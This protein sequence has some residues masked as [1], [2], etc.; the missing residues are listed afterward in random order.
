MLLRRSI[1]S[2][3]G[4]L[5]CLGS[6]VQA[7][8]VVV[9]GIDG[10]DPGLLTQFVD[11]G[12]MPH[13]ARLMEEGDFRPLETSVVPQSP[14][15]WS[16]FSTGL[17]PG[18]HGIYG[19]VH[20]DP[21]TML[22]YLSTSRAISAE[23]SIGLGSFALPLG[24]GKV[25]LLRRGRTFWELLGEHGVPTTL[26]R[27]PANFPPPEVELS[28]QIAGMGTPDLLG[29]PGTYSLYSERPAVDADQFDGGRVYRVEV[30][31]GCVE[32]KLYGPENPYRRTV[33]GGGEYEPSVATADFE[34]GIDRAAGAAR[35]A[36]GEGEFVLQV[37][38]W[39]EWVR[40][41]FELL[42]WLAGT[43][44]L[45]R[46][47]LKRLE[48]HF[49]LYVSPL[50][51]NPEDA[52]MR[53]ST[54]GDW[55]GELCSCLGYF[56]TQ[57]MPEETNA[58]MHG[59]FTGRE[60]FEQVLL[61]YGETR[62]IHEYLQKEHEDGLLFFY[63]GTIDQGCHMLWHYADPEHGLFVEDELLADGIRRLYRE[64]D[65]ML[66]EVLDGLD[67]ETT[68]IVMSDHGF[69]PFYWGVNLNSW[70]LESGYI[71]LRDPAVQEETQ[72][73]DN[74]DWSRTQ[75]Y[76]LGLNGL[77][78]N[79]RGREKEGSVADGEEY[80]RLLD[81]LERELLGM[82]DSRTGLQPVSRVTRPRR[83]FHGPHRESGAD[84]IIGY[85]RGYRSSWENPLG[86]FP[87]EVFV[88][89]ER[90]WSGDH[91]IDHRLVPG[92]LVTNREI[93]MERPALY[94]L[95]VAILDEWGIEALPEMIGRDCLR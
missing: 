37:G 57:G 64:M 45:A 20:R 9:L 68:L 46:F 13:F 32:G 76:A 88:D 26:F 39:S 62:R 23:R 72:L 40:V 73:F 70:L 74:V 1:W 79:L 50:Q 4:L 25:E 58:F 44:G 77:Y 59:A 83:D 21:G 11:E 53:L 54:P 60:F 34:V 80:E 95:T 65:G 55:A 42:P 24:S 82:R 93:S 56:A 29:T 49:E 12:E 85:S 63:Y 5:L 27:M 15:A 3:I 84:L 22:P 35:F 43:S 94:D 7:K 71:A 18:G 78:V 41:D 17:D 92:V 36:V 89:N 38:E 75:A 69:A 86:E 87:R 81:G 33:T 66:G 61:T 14:V 30:V 6:A 51:I 91:C 48:P 31:D 2:M 90:P 67:E 47:Y 19:F 16:T 8:K 52:A 10:M 28:L